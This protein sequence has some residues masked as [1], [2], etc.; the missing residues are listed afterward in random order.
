MTEQ[1][2][3]IHPTVSISIAVAVIA[4]L[5]FQTVPIFDG[6]IA[7][8]TILFFSIPYLLVT[9]LVLI[10]RRTK[11]TKLDLFLI[12]LSLAI[13]VGSIPVTLYT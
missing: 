12:Y 6:G 9:T 10:R 4:L 7:Q 13:A 2:N 5:G 11:P 3:V 8:S 1:K